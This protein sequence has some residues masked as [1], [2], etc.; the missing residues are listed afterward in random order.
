[1]D[2]LNLLSIIVSIAIFISV[3]ELIRKGVLKERYALLWLFSSVVLIFFSVSRYSLD[4]FA[5][6][7]GIY[8]PPSLLFLLA[9]VFLLLINLHFSVVL[10]ALTD[11]NKRLAQDIGILQ[12]KIDEYNNM[13]QGEGE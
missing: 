5:G 13:N 9:F 10:S 8:Y 4:F 3:M 6:L 2:I 12:L 11:K 7:L 1:M